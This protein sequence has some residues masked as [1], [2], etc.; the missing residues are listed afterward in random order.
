MGKLHC[1]STCG[2]ETT[3]C[4]HI[5]PYRENLRQFRRPKFV[6]LI[7]S[8]EPWHLGGKPMLLPKWT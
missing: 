2:C 5:P 4:R 6:E 3:I 8:H 7:L 1:W